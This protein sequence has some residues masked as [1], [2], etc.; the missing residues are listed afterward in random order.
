MTDIDIN[1]LGNHN[2]ADSHPD[3]TGETIPVNPGGAAMGGGST[4]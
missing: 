3:D 4:W 1:P 2:K